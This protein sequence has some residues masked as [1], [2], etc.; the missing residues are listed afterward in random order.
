[1]AT[2]PPAGDWIVRR[3]SARIE[4]L[5][6]DVLSGCGTPAARRSRTS[7]DAD[8]ADG[9]WARPSL[10]ARV[11]RSRGQA[12]DQRQQP[13]ADDHEREVPPPLLAI[14]VA[15]DHLH[16]VVGLLVSQLQGDLDALAGHHP[17]GLQQ[18]HVVGTEACRGPV[19][20]LPSPGSGA[21]VHHVG[22]NVLPLRVVDQGPQR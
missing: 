22:S 17:G 14:L 21:E 18:H 1:V 11:S 16:V 10:G 5:I 4:L 3:T 6:V 8:R 13:L 12:V 7:R 19:G 2:I 9:P 20:A 15:D